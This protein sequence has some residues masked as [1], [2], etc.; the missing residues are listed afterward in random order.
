[1][2]GEPSATGASATGTSRG[3]SDP[4]ATV[5]GASAPSSS[6]PRVITVS[7]PA[8]TANLGVGFDVLG[9]ALSLRANFRFEVADRLQIDGCPA[10][11]AGEDNLVW[12]SYLAAT[13]QLGLP[14]HV[15]HIVEDCPIPMSGGMGS[16]SACVVAGICAA[17]ALSGQ[18]MPAVGDRLTPRNGP[19]PDE[20]TPIEADRKTMLSVA[21]AIE[22]HPDNVAPAILGGLV[23]SFIEKGEDRSGGMQVH[24]LSWNVS[25][26]LR[27]VCMAPPYRVL[28]SEAREALPKEVPLQVVSWQVG[29][30]LALV[31]A[32]ES[33]DEE[34]IA[35]C[36][37]DRVH[38]PYR[39]KLIAD[40]ERL[41]ARSLEAG[42]CAFLISGSGATM[43]AIA[44]G[45]EVASRVADAVQ[46]L[47]PTLWVRVLRS[48]P[49]GVAVKR[50][51]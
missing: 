14:A 49:Q 20:P 38:E 46:E 2:S 42:A 29:R 47:M 25:D 1:M 5:G 23:S 35:S 19:I 27:F 48:E 8:T 15:L 17:Q 41:R 22:G 28:T 24:S 32:L 6:A 34:A 10:Q 9:M 45:E 21:A 40:Y 36:C 26:D 31:R 30:C 39:A 7:V 3:A 13:K 11:F 37:N 51:V 18:S 16:S 44:R 50:L 43:L 33:G 4:T 12:T